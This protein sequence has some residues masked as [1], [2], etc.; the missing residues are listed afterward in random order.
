MSG[1]DLAAANIKGYYS[2]R[3]G[4][5]EQEL[6]AKQ[7]EWRQLSEENSSLRRWA[8]WHSAARHHMQLCASAH[9]VTL[10]LG[11]VAVI[12]VVAALSATAAAST[13]SI[14]HCRPLLNLPP[15]Q[16]PVG[17]ACLT[18]A[19]LTALLP[20]HL[21]ILCVMLL[22]EGAVAVQDHQHAGREPALFCAGCCRSAA[23]ARCA[24][25]LRRRDHRV[26]RPGLAGDTCS[27][28]A[29]SSCRCIICF[30]TA[31]KQQHA[32]RKASRDPGPQHARGM[33]GAVSAPAVYHCP[34]NLGTQSL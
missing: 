14:T 26:P 19:T 10:K 8:M 1:H 32:S 3:V 12:P 34:P 5:L 4:L 7:Q 13:R 23:A 33:C 21:C 22:Q 18:V 9:T 2:R 15:A 24:P 27:S 20:L 11:K 31:T 25:A 29:H 30:R 17:F 16:P 28:S 6:L